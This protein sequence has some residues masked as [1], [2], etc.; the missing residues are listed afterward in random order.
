MSQRSTLIHEVLVRHETALSIRILVC[1]DDLVTCLVQLCQLYHLHLS[2]FR[3]V[4]QSS[5]SG[6]QNMSRALLSCPK[7]LQTSENKL[8]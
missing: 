4:V 5:H 1:I 6:I 3:R 2:D 8:P 7:L